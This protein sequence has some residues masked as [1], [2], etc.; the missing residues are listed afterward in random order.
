MARISPFKDPAPNGIDGTTKLSRATRESIRERLL[1]IDDAIGEDGE[2]GEEAEAESRASWADTIAELKTLE[3]EPT[4]GRLSELAL[5]YEELTLWEEEDAAVRRD[6][7]R[8]DRIEAK[9]DWDEFIANG[10]DPNS[11]MVTR[12]SWGR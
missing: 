5:A 7:R 3:A 11:I 9:R 2:H 6:L 4:H 12:C 1:Q 10:G 8:A